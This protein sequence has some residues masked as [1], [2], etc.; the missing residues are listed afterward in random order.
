MSNSSTFMVSKSRIVSEPKVFGEGDK[1][2]VLARIAVN[3]YGEKNK[4]YYDESYFVDVKFGGRHS[5]RASELKVGDIIAGDLGPIMVRPWTDKKTG[6][7]RRA[8][9]C[10]FPNNFEVYPKEPRAASGDAP[11]NAE[12]A[13]APAKPKKNPFA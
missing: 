3:T 2:V 5:G 1:T 9:E 4:E 7:V 13:P 6:E 8:F 11:A 10:P 12:P